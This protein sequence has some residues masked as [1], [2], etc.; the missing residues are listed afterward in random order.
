MRTDAGPPAPMR[1]RL[2]TSW[3]RLSWR[4]VAEAAGRLRRPVPK[5]SRNRAGDATDHDATPPAWVTSQRGSAARR[6]GL[7]IG[8]LT[9]R[10][11]QQPVSMFIHLVAHALPGL[12]PLTCPEAAWW[13]MRRLREMWPEALAACVMCDHLHLLLETESPR[14][15]RRRLAS[16]LAGCTQ[17]LAQRRLWQPVPAPGQ[18]A[19]RRHLLRNVRYI[20]LNPVRAGLVEDPLCWPWSTHR[21][22]IGAEV[23][24]WVTPAR[25]ARVVGFRGSG[26]VNWISSYTATDPDGPRRGW[27]APRSAPANTTST[28]PLQSIMQAAT[29]ATPQSA[30]SIRRH[31][32][33]LLA[34]AQGWGQTEAVARAAGV[35]RRRVRQLS[36]QAD[37]ELLAA[38]SLCLGDSR[39]T[40]VP[41]DLAPHRE[42]K[43]GN[44]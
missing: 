17:H 15:V 36:R 18:V 19:D 8:G 32:L 34:Q 38:A 40:E 33:V 13:M 25:P 9:L 7:V 28:V 1:C 5:F 10:R 6:L 31:A 11:F 24:P 20:H 2:T 26:F 27:K 23:D 14:R 30:L 43:W 44:R 35:S 37:A 21:G 12:R 4:G 22:L 3:L 29:A 41:R 39:L 42:S 16:V